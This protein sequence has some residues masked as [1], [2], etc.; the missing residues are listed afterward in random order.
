VAGLRVS[1]DGHIE[2]T[3]RWDGNAGV[4][5]PAELAVAVAQGQHTLVLENPGPEWIEV[6]E[7]D[8]GIEVPALA[9]IGRRNDRF[10][11]AWIWNRKNLYAISPSTAAAGTVDLDNV[12][13]GSWK[14]TWWDTLK[15][16]QSASQ[17]IE[18]RGGALKLPTPP[19]MRDAAVVLSRG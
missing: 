16:V 8:L 12:P 5:D 4:P 9:L 17:V 15:G 13:A 3:H 11:E 2:A 7:I 10:I 19:I 18:H 14:V 1:V 6:P